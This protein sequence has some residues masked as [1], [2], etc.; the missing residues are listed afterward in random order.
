MAKKGTNDQGQIIQ[1]IIN[2]KFYKVWDAVRD[3]GFKE[4]PDINVRFQVCREAF[5]SFNP[6]ENN[7]FIYFYKNRLSFRRQNDRNI[8][9]SHFTS[10][11]VSLSKLKTHSLSPSEDISNMVRDISRFQIL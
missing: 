4:I 5:N 9:D 1:D 3:I 10:N 11:Q 6:Y 2:G 8:K 7:N